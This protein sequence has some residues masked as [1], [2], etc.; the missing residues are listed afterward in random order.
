MAATPEYSDLILQHRERA[1]DTGNSR[2]AQTWKLGDWVPEL[3]YDSRLGL[4][5]GLSPRGPYRRARGGLQYR[6]AG[7]QLR[8]PI[9][10]AFNLKTVATKEQGTCQIYQNPAKSQILQTASPTLCE[11]SKSGI[12]LKVLKSQKSCSRSCACS[13]HSFSL[14]YS[15]VR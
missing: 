12:K 13:R 2:P 9:A 5:W 14:M 1:S 10:N 11:I 6:A 3:G 7:F 4:R 8:A 15:R